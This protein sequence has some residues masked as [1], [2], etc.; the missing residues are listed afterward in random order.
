M[1]ILFATPETSDFVQV[2]G[3]AAVSAALPRALR[4]HADIRIVIPGYSEVLVG[5]QQNLTIVGRCAAFAGLPAFDIGLGHAVDGLPYYVILCPGLFERDGTPYGDQRGVDW[6][7][8]DVRFA[9]FSYGAACIALGRVDKDWSADLVHANDW[10]CALI[11]GYLEWLQSRLPTVF[12]IHNLA[13]QGVFD[14]RSMAQ[15]GIPDASF[16]ID[17]VEFYDR[18]SFI[19]AGLVYASHLTTVSQTYAREITTSEF[20][21]GLEGILKKRA[22]KRELSG[23]LNGIDE[24]WDPRTCSSL[25][26]R[27]DVGDWD[28]RAENANEVRR[29]FGLAL[30]RGPL[31]ALVA[32]LVHQKGIDLVLENA[33]TIIDAGGQIVVTGK[34]EERFEQALIEAQE[35]NPASIAVKIGFDD[36]EARRIF[37]GS[38]FTLM[39]SRFEPCG[40]SQMYAQRFGSLPIGHRT[41]G[42]AETIVDGETGFLFE[43]PSSDRFLG[44]LCRAFSAYG[45][46]DQLDRMRRVAMAQAFSWT[47]T[48]KAYAALY[49]TSI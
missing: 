18:L 35:R 36:E 27:F 31:F 24:S 38:D 7:D 3:L 17:G 13:Y 42:L 46:K 2:G 39:P 14:R 25:S 33:K 10:Q 22:D 41:G 34:G 5:L 19:K 15:L 23:I 48:A 30:S 16:H 47:D 8:N 12:T 32:R 49:Q 45:M 37:A 6:S 20:G 21:C 4:E 26:K 40:L 29:Q 1:R 44:G 9:T 11:P 43:R 28:H